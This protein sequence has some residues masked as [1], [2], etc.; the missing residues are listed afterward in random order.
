MFNL[1]QTITIMHRYLPFNYPVLPTNL[2]STLTLNT[3]P[4]RITTVIPAQLRHGEMMV[5]GL[6]AAAYIR[7]SRYQKVHI[8][9]TLSNRQSLNTHN[10]L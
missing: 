10:Q 7:C 3:T 1:T 2:S 5:K 9:L 4:F 8:I 6:A